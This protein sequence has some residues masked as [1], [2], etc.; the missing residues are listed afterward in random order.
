MKRFLFLISFIL[1]FW[2]IWM[3]YPDKSVYFTV[4]DVG[5]GDA[6]L[7]SKGFF[8]LLIDTG[9]DEGLISCL[10]K[11]VPFWDKKIDLLVLTHFDAD[12]IGAFKE[13]IN[14]YQIGAIYLPLTDSKE[15]DLYLELKSQIITLNEQGTVIKEPFLGQQIAFYDFTRENETKYNSIT[16]LFLTFLTPFSISEENY[17][18]L[19]ELDAFSWQKTETILSDNNLGK[20][21]SQISENNRSIVFLL[22]YGDLL[23]LLTGDLETPGEEA[24]MRLSLINRV[25]V[26]KVGHHGAKTSTSM[27]FLLELRPETCLIS[28]GENNK[29]GHP[30]IEVIK[31]IS[32]IGSNIFRTDT[33]GELNFILDGEHFYL[34]DI[35]NTIH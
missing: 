3:K 9:P 2:Q 21:S 20:I 8:Q 24:M 12:H 27:P 13:L 17:L 35:K 29:F 22:Q 28:A 30:N 31:R 7:F 6:L 15:S 23:F 4:C 14:F 1:F 5:Q 32:S 33:Q 11:N 19:E 16:P 25:D 26:L 34:K 18:Q 10:N